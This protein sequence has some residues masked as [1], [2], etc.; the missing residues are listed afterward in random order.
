MCPWYVL[1]HQS[2]WPIRSRQGTLWACLLISM[3]QQD[4]SLRTLIFKQFWKFSPYV[5]LLCLPVMA[6][7]IAIIS[8]TNTII[9]RH[10][11]LQSGLGSSRSPCFSLLCMQTGFSEPH[12]TAVIY[13][14]ACG[15]VV[16]KILGA[17]FPCVAMTCTKNFCLCYS[18]KI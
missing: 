7:W 8:R 17:G 12:V 10:C 2:F 6:L 3:K 9:I 16:M 5:P 15:P 4:N 13:S 18:T 14:C 1:C 11:K